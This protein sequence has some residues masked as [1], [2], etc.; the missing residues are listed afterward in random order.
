MVSYYTV[1][2]CVPDPFAD[3]RMNVG[4]VV[5]GDGRVRSRFLRRWDRVEQ[6]AGKEIAAYARSFADRFA[7]ASKS[8][9]EGEVQR[10]LKGPLA[11]RR[12]D[13]ARLRDMMQDASNAVQFSSAQSSL[14]EPDDLLVELA[15]LFLVEHSTPSH[16]L[17]DRRHAAEIAVSSLEAAVQERFNLDSAKKLV[18]SPYEIAG[19]VNLS[20]KVDAA[21][22]N[23][24]VYDV[25]EAFS[26][27]RIDLDQL[28]SD[29]I[30]ALLG[31]K[32]IR[33]RNKNVGRFDILA[34]RPRKE[35]DDWRQMDQVLAEMAG[36]CKRAGATLV[37]NDEAEDWA[38]EVARTIP[39]DAV[40]HI[41]RALLDSHV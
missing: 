15:R 2:H 41:D 27:E 29:V 18:K 24:H 21:V 13:E 36:A 22:T 20:Y 3:E 16:R 19:T 40:S 38:T 23:G 30:N 35:L 26:F 28:K 39:I 12:I 32:D 11:G 10:P 7:L 1:V 5:F 34:L 17:R 4:V 9:S 37:P 25:V 8:S 33:D 6:F 14:R 31:F